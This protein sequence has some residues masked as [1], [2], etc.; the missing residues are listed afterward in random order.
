M[1]RMQKKLL[2]SA[3]SALKE[4]GV[5]VYSTCTFA[6]EENEGVVSEVVGKS[7]GVLELEVEATHGLPFRLI[8]NQMAGLIQWEGKHF[9]P[10]LKNAVRIL[11]TS[12]MEGFFIAR[13][14]KHG[15]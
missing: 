4:G 11:P 14:R 3:F 7:D 15:K 12:E 8:P 13:I 6:P 9:H 10:S 2:I 5:L 1:A